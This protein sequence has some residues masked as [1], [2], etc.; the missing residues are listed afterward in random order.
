MDYYAINR[1]ADC[2]AYVCDKPLSLAAPLV[3]QPPGAPTNIGTG[4]PAVTDHGTIIY[5][6]N[7]FVDRGFGHGYDCSSVEAATRYEI[8]C[9]AEKGPDSTADR[10]PI[11]KHYRVDEEHKAVCT[12]R[13]RRYKYSDRPTYRN[14][15]PYLAD[16]LPRIDSSEYPEVMSPVGVIPH[17][18]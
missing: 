15:F 12:E 1:F 16:R 10:S 8:H 2:K 11:Q 4:T 5:S 17:H 14:P 7:P 18:F 13:V 6:F 9:L 3:R